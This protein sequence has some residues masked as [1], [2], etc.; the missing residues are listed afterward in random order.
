MRLGRDGEP[1]VGL[2]KPP[3]LIG[4]RSDLDSFFLLP[5]A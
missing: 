4:S 3:G 1:V 2:V 5:M